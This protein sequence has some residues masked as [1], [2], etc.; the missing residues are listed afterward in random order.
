M[1]KKIKASLG[2][3]I[4]VIISLILVNS[5]RAQEDLGEDVIRGA[6]LYDNLLLELGVEAPDGTHPL[7]ETQENETLSGGDTWLCSTCHAFDYLGSRE[8]SETAYPALTGQTDLQTEEVLDWLDGTNNPDHDYSEYLDNGALNDLAAFLQSGILDVSSVF[9]TETRTANG[10][11]EVGEV[12]Y[13][14][15]C[16]ACHGADGSLLNFGTAGQPVFIGDAALSNPWSFIHRVRFGEPKLDS[17]AFAA[18]DGSLEYAADIL[19]FAQVFPQAPSIFEEIEPEFEI[20]DL[21][22]EGDTQ[23][24]TIGA[25]VIVL[26]ILLGIAWPAYQKR[27]S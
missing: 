10:D 21:E 24:I 20:I 26:V 11:A 13:T 17:H 6:H 16:A 19:A 27:V 7:W 1:S 14:R 18:G 4:F 8:A 25:V 15:I 23:S 12:I 3:L 22:G 2:L 9:N 5:T